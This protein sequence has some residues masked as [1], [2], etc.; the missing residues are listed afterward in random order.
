[1]S[2]KDEP[3]K[4]WSER[5]TRDWSLRGV[6]H[7]RYSEYYNHYL[8]RAKVRALRRMLRQHRIAIAG[9]RVL[10]VGAGIGFWL[11]WYQDADAGAAQLTA[12]DISEAATHRLRAEFPSARVW[13]GD[14]AEEWPWPDRF[15]LINAFD[16]LY[17]I[18][19]R[20]RFLNALT[21]MTRHLEPGG[22]L[23]VTDLFPPHEVR[24]G[25]HVCFH[26]L[27]DYRKV[28]DAEGCTILGIRPLY[29]LMNGV[30]FDWLGG[31]RQRWREMLRG[32]ENVAAPLLYAL[33]GLWIP[34]SLPNTKLLIAR[35]SEMDQ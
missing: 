25:V 9:K 7:I 8:Y 4:F 13:L 22:Y 16:V 18:I 27:E 19:E 14:V 30:V 12:I 2:M 23:V 32:F 28:L 1:M 11:R 17:H 35:R 6:G 5:L 31:P 10:D 29:G 24:S 21:Q 3:T 34:M 20:S 15:D 33:D 26:G